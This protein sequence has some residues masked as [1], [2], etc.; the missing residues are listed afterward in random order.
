M[1]LKCLAYIAWSLSSSPYPSQYK[2]NALPE[3]WVND[4]LNL[5]KVEAR[6]VSS[7]KNFKEPTTLKAEKLGAQPVKILGVAAEYLEP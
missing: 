2:I 7:E 3:S 5:Y 4:K 6:A 1:Y